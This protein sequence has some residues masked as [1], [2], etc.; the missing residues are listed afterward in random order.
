MLQRLSLSAC[1]KRARK[2]ALSAF[3][4]NKYLPLTLAP[5][6][7]RVVDAAT[8]HN[9]MQV[10][11]EVETSGIGMQDGGHGD[12]G[13]EETR[14]ESEVFECSGGDI[15]EQIIDAGLM[16]PGE[17]SQ[18]PGQC[19]G[20]H[21]V[22][23]GEQFGALS[24]EPCVGVMVMALGTTAVAAGSR[25]GDGLVCADV[26]ARLSAAIGFYGRFPENSKTS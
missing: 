12:V 24:V 15:E 13:T 9:D 26:K 8:G 10:R 5:L 11:M 25:L 16:A 1:R 6:A 3:S 14:I 21:E 19:E 2:T 17:W 18:I 20:D 22:V 23:D 4:S 7:A